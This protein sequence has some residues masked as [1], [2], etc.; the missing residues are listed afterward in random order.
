[1]PA[2]CRV[3]CACSTTGRSI[4]RPSSWAAPGDAASAAQH[5]PRPVERLRARRQRGVDRRDLARVDAQLGAE[6]V[7]ARPGEVG[8]QPRLV[9]ELRA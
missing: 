9:V 2:R 1:M 4:I 6:A 8:Q 5:A 7:A 3:R